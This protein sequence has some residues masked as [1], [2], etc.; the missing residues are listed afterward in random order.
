MS[1]YFL[2]IFPGITNLTLQVV[3]LC[4]GGALLDR[5]RHSQK[6]VLLLSQLL[7]YAVQIVEGMSYLESKSF[8]HRDL[9]A[10]NVL[11]AT[12]DEVRKITGFLVHLLQ[13]IV[14][15]FYKHGY[16]K[17]A[18]TSYSESCSVVIGNY[19]S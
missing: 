7:S 15:Y 8:I 3:E 4:S 6:P 12:E 9:A 19:G 18:A 1:I 5:L 11:L 10:R 16:S 2:A 14:D 17:S 13:T